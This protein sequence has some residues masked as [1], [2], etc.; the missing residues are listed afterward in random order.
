M[1]R[2]PAT[3]L[4][5]DPEHIE[6]AIRD[7]HS[8]LKAVEYLDD[9]P[10]SSKA[11]DRVN[12]SLARDYLERCA[13]LDPTIKDDSPIDRRA[14][15]YRLLDKYEKRATYEIRDEAIAT[16]VLMVVTKHG[17]KPKR[18]V[19]VTETDKWQSACSIVQKALARMGL[20]LDE[21][22]IVSIWDAR[23]QRLEDRARRERLAR[24]RAG[25]D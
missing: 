22:N 15:L 21:A 18:G 19:N 16:A 4:A 8:Y 20:T 13:V 25:I 12:C 23:R 1:R 5:A 24:H 2:K 14:F 3:N 11:T 7:A 10:F 17:F 6:A 9:R